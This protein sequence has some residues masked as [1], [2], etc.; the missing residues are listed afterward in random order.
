[1]QTYQFRDMTLSRL[2]L[3]TAQFGLDYGIANV[4]GQPSYETARDIMACAWEGGVNSFDTAAGYGTSEEVIGRAISELGIAD[5]VIIATKVSYRSHEISPDDADRKMEDSVVNSL[6]RLRLDILPICLIHLEDNFCYMDSLLKLKD[7]GLVRYVGC[8]TMTPAKT[9]EIIRSGLVDAVQIPTSI[10]DHRFV[11]AGVISEAASRNVAVF[12]RSIYLQGLLVMDEES[13]PQDLVNV[14]PY[15]QRLRAL[16]QENGMTLR[17]L[18][19]SYIL[20]LDGVACAVV[21]VDSVEQMKEN[22]ELFSRQPLDKTL[23][24]AVNDAVQGI[25]EHILNPTTWAPKR[26]T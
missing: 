1:M 3:G 17:E 16:A 14:I 11:E 20:S 15:R 6:K 22:L 19:V 4:M 18:A 8:S 5:R 26:R 12:T 21:G 9:L 10:L 24:E 2:M 23:L 7:R 13:T 25:P